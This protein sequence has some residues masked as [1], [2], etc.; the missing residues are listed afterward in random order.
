MGTHGWE[1]V[2]GE[3]D[4]HAD[5]DY[6]ERGEDQWVVTVARGQTLVREIRPADADGS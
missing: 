6:A 1:R 2:L 3:E 5:T 4:R